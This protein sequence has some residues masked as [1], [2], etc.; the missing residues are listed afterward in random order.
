[1]IS[2]VWMAGQRMTI[3]MLGLG[4]PAVAQDQAGTPSSATVALGHLATPQGWVINLGPRWGSGWTNTIYSKDKAFLESSQARK[5][6]LSPMFTQ[7][8]TAPMVQKF[9]L[10][11]TAPKITVER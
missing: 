1:M 10:F 6:L 9:V 5:R 4:T 11:A 3:A 2:G 7:S 8:L